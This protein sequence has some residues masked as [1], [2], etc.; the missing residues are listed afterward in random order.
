MKEISA[1]CNGNLFIR[2]CIVEGSTIIHSHDDSDRYAHSY[3]IKGTPR[4]VSTPKH[5]YAAFALGAGKGCTF[6]L[7]HGQ[8]KLSALELDAGACSADRN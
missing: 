1:T 3:T 2:H 4:S 5:P 8:E 7:A 6:E